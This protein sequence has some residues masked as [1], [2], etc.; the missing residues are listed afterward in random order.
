MLS[1]FYGDRYIP[2]L[3]NDLNCTGSELS[4]LNCPSNALVDYTCGRYDDAAVICQGTMAVKHNYYSTF[5][6]A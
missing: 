6:L 1:G 5:S 2:T 4:F 3:I